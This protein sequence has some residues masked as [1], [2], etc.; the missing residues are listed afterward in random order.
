M[1]TS[2][3]ARRYAY[4]L[5]LTVFWSVILALASAPAL[6]ACVRQGGLAW[7]RPQEA[8]E[9]AT[10][11]VREL[12]PEEHARL[13]G[14]SR[15]L[16]AGPLAGRLRAA[17]ARLGSS[18]RAAAEGLPSDGL[19]GQAAPV[20][21]GAPA[22]PG[23]APADEGVPPA[24]D[25]VPGTAQGD[26]TTS[27]ALAESGQGH[28]DASQP[29]ATLA[30][31]A[32]PPACEGAPGL[33]FSTV[34]AWLAADAPADGSVGRWQPGWYI[35]HWWAPVGRA[36]LG[37]AEGDTFEADGVRHVVCGAFEV[38]KSATDADVRRAIGRKATIL[39]TCV[40]LSDRNRIVWSAA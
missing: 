5:R 12:T 28:G 21:A 24:C 14:A 19:D 36:V 7:A 6:I 2:P 35:V 4:A 11:V 31:P 34:D 29:P 17:V 1:N 9:Q 37:L 39:Q 32:A 23:P 8:R 27:S 16:V 30:A 10:P 26:G 3:T 20:G 22:S 33:A 40:P 18:V 15:L 38:P 25:A 13:R